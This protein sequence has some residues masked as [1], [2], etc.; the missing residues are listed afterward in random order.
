M[1]ETKWQVISDEVHSFLIT[2]F[3]LAHFL[4]LCGEQEITAQILGSE[5]TQDVSLWKSSSR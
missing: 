3:N 5:L 4:P 2:N 1:F